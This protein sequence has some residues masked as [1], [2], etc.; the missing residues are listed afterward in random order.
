M[1]WS[2]KAKARV[3]K[4]LLR[5]KGYEHGEALRRPLMSPHHGKKKWFTCGQTRQGWHV[6]HDFTEIGYDIKSKGA[7]FLD[8]LYMGGQALLDKA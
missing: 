5:V 7:L 4:L 8:R 1:D 3:G 2:C 6:D